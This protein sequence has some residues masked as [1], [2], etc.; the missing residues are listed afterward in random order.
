VELLPEGV[1]AISPNAAFTHYLGV[2]RPIWIRTWTK[3]RRMTEHKHEVRN[4]WRPDSSPTSRPS[5]PVDHRRCVA[6]RAGMPACC[7]PP[8]SPSD[9]GE[10]PPSTESS[11]LVGGRAP[12]HRMF[13]GWDVGTWLGE[14]HPQCGR[15]VEPPGTTRTPP[16]RRAP[17]LQH[18]DVV[19]P[20]G[21]MRQPAAPHHR[22]ARPGISV[23][24]RRGL[25]PH[26]ALQLSMP[27]S[28]HVAEV[29]RR[30]P[31]APGGWGPRYE[32]AV[33]L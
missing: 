23:C 11:P 9:R 26:T 19:W 6:R 13:P 5:R 14:G 32:Q 21:C 2:F 8:P 22:R 10:S 27:P 4:R 12:S 17:P 18:T 29:V 24:W 31:E 25:T 28:T 30:P 3:T 7:V 15:L 1:R 16:G 20:L 33:K